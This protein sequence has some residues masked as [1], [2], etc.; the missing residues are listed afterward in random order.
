MLNV[1][2]HYLPLLRRPAYLDRPRAREDFEVNIKELMDFGVLRKVGHNEQVDVTTPIIITWK[3]GKSM[4]VGEF[5]AFNT[6]TIPDRYQIP[7][8]HEKLTQLPQAKL[9]TAMD[10]LKVFHQNV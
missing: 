7:R 1:E 9:T 10:S 2:K 4:M 6:Y 8:I 5:R 3:N